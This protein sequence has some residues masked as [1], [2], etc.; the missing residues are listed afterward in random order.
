MGD[1]ERLLLVLVIA[2]VAVAFALLLQRRQR[3]AAPTVTGYNV[4]DQLDRADFDHPGTP[5]LVVVFTSKT[6]DTCAGV[7]AKAR[8]LQAP[9]AVAVQEVEVTARRDLHDRY[10]IEGVP[11]TLVV[12]ASGVVR[13][14]FLGPVTASDL[15]ATLAEMRQPGTL[16][17]NACNP[18]EQR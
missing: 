4:P 9:G 1:V 8:H 11:A 7:W 10:R 3:S 18:R 14:S 16:P 15:W 13:A 17:P 12:D 5:W 2:A 6:C